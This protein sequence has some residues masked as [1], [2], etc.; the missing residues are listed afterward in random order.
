MKP[1]YFIKEWKYHTKISSKKR[2]F[3]KFLLTR[4]PIS[5]LVNTS[6]YN[7]IYSGI[8]SKKTKT[9]EPIFLQIETTNVC[10]GKCLMCPH[11]NMK[12]KPKVMNQK[13]FEKIVDNVL[14][15]YKIKRI[16]LSGFGEPL[17]DLG[18]IEKIKFLNKKYPNVK[19][20]FFTNGSMLTE[21]KAGELLKLKI[22]KI[23]FSI[24]GTENNYNKVTGMDYKRTK[25]N[26][27]NFLK[28]REKMRRKD[29]LVNMSLMILDQNK[30][31]LDK[32]YKTWENKADS[33]MM[34]PPSS[35]W[36]GKIKIPKL[37]RISKNWPCRPLWR[38][39]TV[40]VDG[41]VLKCW[42]DIESEQKFG[43]LLKQNIKE[44]YLSE[45]FNILRQEHLKNKFNPPLCNNC[46]QS[47]DSSID[48][49]TF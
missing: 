8:V 16:T 42:K 45:N 20:D 49:W 9:I 39:I 26:I 19:I 23:V 27:D 1:S 47:I 17:A 41:N 44:I 2:V 5:K 12:R 11:K 29:I 46:D 18:L 22:E 6:L 4:T 37:L 40:D 21:K 30:N 3:V 13:N 43:N 48:W 32:F 28:L 36:A 34:Y 7:K 10:N 14:S 38:N 35:T 24:N 31:E 25:R 33:V 15:S